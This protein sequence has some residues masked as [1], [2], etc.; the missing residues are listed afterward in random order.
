M[1]N[2]RNGGIELEDPLLG[3]DP[4]GLV[5]L[6]SCLAQLKLWCQTAANSNNYNLE[7]S[8]DGIFF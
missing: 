8:L 4:F 6:C 5:S 2:L 7:E 3:D 1:R